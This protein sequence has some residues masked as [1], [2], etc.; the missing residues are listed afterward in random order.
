MNTQKDFTCIF[1]AYHR[2]SAKEF[3]FGVAAD[4][5]EELNERIQKLLY[6]LNES[7][8]LDEG[9]IEKEKLDKKE[10]ICGYVVGET[11]NGEVCVFLYQDQ[12]EYKRYTL[13][14]EDAHLLPDKWPTKAEWQGAAPTLDMARKKGVL[15]EKRFMLPVT[16]VVDSEGNIKRNERGYI[17]YRPK[18]SANLNGAHKADKDGSTPIKAAKDAYD[19]PQLYIDTLLLDENLEFVLEM[20]QEYASKYA[21][22]PQNAEQKRR[23]EQVLQNIVKEINAHITQFVKEDELSPE[24]TQT[25]L[26][27]LFNVRPNA[28]T[29]GMALMLAERTLP[30]M[31]DGSKNPKRDEKF[32]EKLSKAVINTLLYV[33]AY[34]ENDELDVLWETAEHVATEELAF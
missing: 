9:E 27:L 6:V 29:K 25:A 31:A 2:E 17:V 4:D 22:L 13:Y 26:F 24:D 28:L 21:K 18:R 20:R 34:R 3:T 7:F 8:S 33:K 15:H 16:P 12:F 10:D 23:A 11:S 19:T 32:L 30:R 14:K 1:R 5:P